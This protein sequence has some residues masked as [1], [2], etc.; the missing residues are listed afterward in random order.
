MVL[1]IAL[2][3]PIITVFADSVEKPIAKLNDE[4]VIMMI[5]DLLSSVP[6]DTD[7]EIFEVWLFISFE[8]V[9]IGVNIFI[10][11]VKPYYNPAI[12][13]FLSEDPHWNIRNM[14]FGDNPTMRNGRTVPNTHAILQSGNLFVFTMNDPVNFIDPSGL[15]ALRVHF[16]YTRIWAIDAG[17]TS[18]QALLIATANYGVDLDWPTA[19]FN[20]V[21]KDSSWHF[22]TY[23]NGDSRLAHAERMLEIA[24]SQWNQAVMDFETS[25]AS[26]SSTNPIARWLEVRGFESQRDSLMITALENLGRGSHALQDYFS[27]GNTTHHWP[28]SGHDNIDFDWVCN[29]ARTDVRRVMPSHGARFFETQTATMAYFSRF[30]AGI[31]GTSTLSMMGSSS[32]SNEQLRSSARST[33]LRR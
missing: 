6:I 33:Q 12:G 24:I 11:H 15:W 28:F 14:Q 25:M 32:A 13:R 8:I 21:N 29:V 17:F 19:S 5:D 9:G 18:A 31:G 4:A 20:F 1:V 27:H 3:M 7:L 2:M 16:F 10:C 23:A 30:L 26:L 22:N